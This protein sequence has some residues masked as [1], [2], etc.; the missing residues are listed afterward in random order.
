MSQQDDER[1]ARKLLDLGTRSDRVQI[2][3]GITYLDGY[4]LG[5][6]TVEIRSQVARDRRR[7]EP[8]VIEGYAAAILYEV[9]N[10][11]NS[12]VWLQD[13]GGTP[14]LITTLPRR[15]T[16][17]WTSTRLS[18]ASPP[19]LLGYIIRQSL[20]AVILDPKDAADVINSGFV[21][22]ENLQITSTLE[23]GSS[24]VVAQNTD[25][26]LGIN[27]FNLP[28]G[29]GVDNFAYYGP[30]FAP[31]FQHLY[32]RLLHVSDASSITL[33][34]MSNQVSVFLQRR[35]GNTFVYLRH[36]PYHSPGTPAPDRTD[37]DVW[38]E[39]QYW[40]NGTLDIDVSE[41]NPLD[42]TGH[43]VADPKRFVY[44]ISPE[45]PMLSGIGKRIFQGR[46]VVKQNPYEGY[47]TFFFTD[48]FLTE[49]GVV[50]NFAFSKEYVTVDANGD[51]S[52]FS[53]SLSSDFQ[54]APANA[55][56]VL[57]VAIYPRG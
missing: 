40:V 9:V 19:S 21:D 34:S 45:D 49:G 53:E 18:S 1:I 47:S 13:D 55:R 44:D 39:S 14:V 46:N 6:G 7:R 20:D 24:S 11:T 30:N 27:L 31:T 50:K 10:G 35:R 36:N 8:V 28:L 12:E 26:T 51:P 29:T 2:R 5:N 16:L 17:G 54:G 15:I 52:F 42:I 3:N 25:A 43:I 41:P 57:S 32:S 56:Q 37:G 38:M 4:A 22:K 48:L 33:N 23:N